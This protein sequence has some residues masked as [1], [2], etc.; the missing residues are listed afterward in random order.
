MQKAK[1]PS[2][3]HSA[4]L[5]EYAALA[6]GQGNATLV[7]NIF[8]QAFGR[9]ADPEGLAYYTGVLANGEKTLA[10]IATTII[11]AAGGIDAQTFN[12]RVE[13]AAAYTAEF[14]SAA[15]YDLVAA[16]EAVASAEPGLF[17]PNVTP[18]IEELQAAQKAV[19]DFLQDEVAANETIAE[20]LETNAADADKPTDT[21]IE[22]AL[23]AELSLAKTGVENTAEFTTLD[24]TASVAAAQIAAQKEA[25]AKDVVDAKATVGE[26]T[27]LQA[28]INSLLA[29]EGRLETA[30]KAELA[31]STALNGEFAKFAALNGL[32]ATDY[33]INDNGTV[34]LTSNNT[35][36]VENTNGK[37][38]IADGF[39]KS[40]G[41]DALVSASQAQFDADAAVT[42]RTEQFE[43]AAERVINLDDDIDNAVVASGTEY[44][45]NAEGEVTITLDAGAYNVAD[46][47]AL[48]NAEA[49]VAA[50]D[51]AVE[52]YEELAALSNQ[53][54]TLTDAVA[55]AKDAFDDLD[56]N[57][58]DY[59]A[60]VDGTDGND[61]ILFD[62]EVSSSVFGS[63]AADSEF[64]SA[65]EDLLF[66]G[67][68]FQLVQLENDAAAEFL[69]GTDFSANV[70]S[71][72]ALEIFWAQNG[73][74]LQLFVENKAFAGNSTSGDDFSTI[75]LTGVSASDITFEGGYLSA[76]VPA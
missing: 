2:S 47:Q 7:D 44:S 36:V 69:T 71:D 8:Q 37:L 32:T 38:S 46:A 25:Y 24:S 56:I 65:G 16:K 9:P 73:N 60:N 49:D 6:E 66:F 58:V 17:L 31:T 30:L 64:G 74:D 50:F 48:L 28:A 75:T 53:Y 72:S 54:T 61:L 40:K 12:A 51:K 27:G 10:E 20:N 4:T 29:A 11:N 26:T 45:V 68:G 22:A 76:G 70:G 21:E 62:S 5:N 23:T 15:D 18:A 63:A 55:D 13:A 19:S 67:E 34:Q 41:V 14:G 33:T 39:A 52:A 43:T 3:T 59:A 42:T 1:A 57:I 35:F